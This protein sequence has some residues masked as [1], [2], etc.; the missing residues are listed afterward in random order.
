MVTR[1]LCWMLFVSIIIAS[2]S[3]SLQRYYEHEQLQKGKAISRFLFEQ[4]HMEYP[5]A[6]ARFFDIYV[7]S[8]DVTLGDISVYKAPIF[9]KD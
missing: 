5:A 2:L 8:Y 3:F 4:H 1:N 7:T 6:E 9:K